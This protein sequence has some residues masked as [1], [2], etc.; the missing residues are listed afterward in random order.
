MELG[1]NPIIN[2]LI[3]HTFKL[4]ILFLEKNHSNTF[5]PDKTIS[6]WSQVTMMFKKKRFY[7]NQKKRCE[8]FKCGPPRQACRVK[9]SSSP[10]KIIEVTHSR[11]SGRGRG[12]GVIIILLKLFSSKFLI[13]STGVPRRRLPPEI[14]A[15]WR[16]RLPSNNL[17][18]H[19]NSHF[20]VSFNFGFDQEAQKCL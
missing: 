17:K 19:Y 6:C 15:R 11:K 4:N 2:G 3:Q 10:W 7:E 12:S 8:I 9:K 5:L 18:A 14:A 13:L 16:Y 1:W 20:F